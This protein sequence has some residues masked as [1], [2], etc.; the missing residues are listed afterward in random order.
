MRKISSKS[1]VIVSAVAGLTLGVSGVAYAFW[2][3][4]GTG[5]G[6]GSTGTDAGVVVTGT[7]ATALTPATSSSV[8]FTV[9]NNSA[10]SPQQLSSIHLVSV[11]AYDTAAN[12]DAHGATGLIAS[13]GGANAGVSE[14]ADGSSDFWMADVTVPVA[15]GAIAANATAQALTSTG[16]LTMNNLTTE[17]QDSCK[18]AFLYLTYTSS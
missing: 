15:D 5:S 3:T 17:N 8:T 13:C 2:T 1:K 12:R 10:T 14:T 18:S 9:K 11:A 16:T 6:T 7:A 4:S